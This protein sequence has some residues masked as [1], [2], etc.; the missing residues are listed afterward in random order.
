MGRCV[1]VHRPRQA[2]LLLLHTD[3]VASRP[4]VTVARF[5]VAFFLAF[6]IHLYHHLLHHTRTAAMSADDKKLRAELVDH[7]HSAVEDHED[8]MAE[9]E[10]LY[11]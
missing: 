10:P 4:S 8:V 2:I 6:L 11:P 5:W 9:C 7:F 1:L 3:L